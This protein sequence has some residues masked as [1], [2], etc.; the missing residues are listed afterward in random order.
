[1][2]GLSNDDIRRIIA[3]GDNPQAAFDRLTE[4]ADPRRICPKL[5]PLPPY[6]RELEVFEEEIFDRIINGECEPEIVV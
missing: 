6:T 3:E 5:P 4:I 1:L 2:Q